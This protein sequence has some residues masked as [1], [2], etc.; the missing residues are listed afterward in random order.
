MAVE[1][2]SQISEGVKI[3]GTLNFPGSNLLEI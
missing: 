2:I 1:N 3:D